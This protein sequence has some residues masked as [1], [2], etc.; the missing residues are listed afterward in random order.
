MSSKDHTSPHKHARH[1]KHHQ[2][3][4]RRLLKRL[5]SLIN[6]H[7]H[8]SKGSRPSSA[9]SSRPASVLSS[10]RPSGAQTPLTAEPSPIEPAEP[11]TNQRPNLK[12]RLVTF[13]M[14]DSLPA[15]TGDLSEFLGDLSQFPEDRMSRKRRHSS[16][17][18]KGSVLTVPLPDEEEGLPRFPL[19]EGHPY[20]VLVVCGQECPTASG[21]LAGKVQR[22]DGKGWTSKLESYLCGGC[23][24]SSPSSSSEEGASSEDDDAA[25]VPSRPGRGPYVLVEKERLMGIY[26]AVFVAKCC[27]GLIKGVS[28]GRVTAGL[29]GGR[30]GNKGG[31]G[32]SLHLHQTRLLFVS[33]HL[34]AHASGLEFRKANAL[35]IL[36]ELVV[37]DF[38]D[39]RGQQGPRPEKL[40][41]RF[42]AVF[43]AGD[44]NFRLNI[45]RLHADWLVRA[46]DYTT[47]LRFDQLRD[48]LASPGGCF[49]GFT[50]GDITF[51]P[52]YKYDCAKEK[53]G[54]KKRGTLMRLAGAG[55]AHDKA[56]ERAATDPEVPSAALTPPPPLG[57]GG[58]TTDGA[59]TATEDDTLS[60]VSSAGTISTMD[61]TLD[62]ALDTPQAVAAR[63]DLAALGMPMPPMKGDEAGVEAARKAQVRFLT[64]VKRNSNVAALEY[65]RRARDASEG[66]TGGGARPRRGTLSALFPPRPILR[67]SQS[68]VV[69]PTTKIPAGV[70]ESDE[71]E[72]DPEVKATDE[73]AEAAEPVFDTSKKQRVQSWTDRILFRTHIPP[74]EPTSPVSV[75]SPPILQPV[76]SPQRSELSLPRRPASADESRRLRF[77]TTSAD[78]LAKSPSVDETTSIWRR[79]KSL[80]FDPADSATS[81]PAPSTPPR[82]PRPRKKFTLSGSGSSSDEDLSRHPSPVA[83]VERPPLPHSASDPP[84]LG[85]RP[86]QHARVAEPRR[87]PSSSGSGEGGRGGGGGG[88]GGGGFPRAR[89]FS[90]ALNKLHERTPTLGQGGGGHSA[91]AVGSGSPSG[92]SLNTRLRS[93]L[94]LLPLRTFASTPAQPLAAPVEQVKK[95]EKVGPREGEVQVLKYDS[96]RDIAR[97]GAVS[98]HRPVFLVCALGVAEDVEQPDEH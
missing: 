87:R 4:P 40:V 53:G 16:R 9:A 48:V 41:D 58:G 43:F 1:Y 59:T 6:P 38:W 30:M 77:R 92:T 11:L 75:L 84:A 29:M 68:A 37:D 97:M 31:V 17:S 2:P 74:P 56:R 90:A 61:T 65:A 54:R 63:E 83:P 52:T 89:T 42:E 15:P 85:D 88:G 45:S 82:R 39:E 98:D 20:H 60:I 86:P 8:H 14:H 46:K 66:S 81:P 27:E 71:P 76:D 49:D 21:V 19:T 36:D 25:S 10:L 69:V 26:C 55:R 23:S 62:S 18:S 7:K 51:P 96:V 93:F 3:A 5:N 47:A 50:E 91:G 28:T 70:E 12:V 33:A 67:T 78:T 72:P 35:K 57:G 34:A 95:A 22:F 94:S 80:V 24:H 13:N 64:L 32:I 79:A 73:E 44:L